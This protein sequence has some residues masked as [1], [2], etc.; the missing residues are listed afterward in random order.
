MGTQLNPSIL[1]APMIDDKVMEAKQ[2]IKKKVNK[3]CVACII[4]I[5]LL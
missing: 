5:S 3:L 4:V 2:I 1:T